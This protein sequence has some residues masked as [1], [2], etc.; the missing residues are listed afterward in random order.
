MRPVERRA[1]GVDVVEALAGERAFAEQ[2]LIGVGHCSGVGI[3]TGVPGK[4]SGER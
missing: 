4:E 3:D 1:E 2:V